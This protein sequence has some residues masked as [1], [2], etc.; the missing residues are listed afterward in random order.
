MFQW[1]QEEQNCF[2]EL[3][4]VLT[5]RPVLKFYDT[6]RELRIS[7][8]ASKSGLGAILL[9]RHDNHWL[10][11]AYSSRAMTTK[12]KNY[13]QIEKEMLAITFACERFHQFIRCMDNLFK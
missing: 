5:S 3:K 12:E 4:K 2:E 11:V 13:A 10:P 7:S 6:D 1:K 8:D 9:H